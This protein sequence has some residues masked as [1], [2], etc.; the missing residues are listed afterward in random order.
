MRKG[1][2]KT[3]PYIEGIGPFKTFVG[4]DPPHRI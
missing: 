2:I 1:E 3:N 4:T